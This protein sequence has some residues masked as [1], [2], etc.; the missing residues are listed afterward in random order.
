MATPGGRLAAQQVIDALQQFVHVD[1]L[2]RGRTPGTQHGVQQIGETIRFADDH[3]RVFPQRR[4]QKFPLEQL[5]RTAQTA[6]R[7]FDFVR[8]LADHQAAAA[9]LRQQRV[10]ARQAPM[11]RDVLDLQQQPQALAAHEHLSHR[12]IEDAVHASRGRPRKLALHDAFTAL[13]R[14]LEHRQQTLRAARQF[15]D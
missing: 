12:T 1:Q 13:A 11:L 6:E 15:S 4:I 8:E 10:L 3:A 7:I 5:R 9:Q 2:L 14:A